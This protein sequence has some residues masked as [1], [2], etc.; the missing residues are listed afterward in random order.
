MLNIFEKIYNE[1]YCYYGPQKWW[2]AKTKLEI[3]VGAVLTQN[4]SWRNA[5]NAISNL[6]KNKLLSLRRLLSIDDTDLALLI[7]SSGY[8]NLKAKRLKNL[9]IFL[10]NEY[11]LS[12]SRMFKSETDFLREQLLSLYGFGEE[13]VDCILLYAGQRPVFVV[14]AYTRRIFSRHGLIGAK[15][16]YALIQAKITANIKN[17]PALFNEYHALIVALGKSIC[18]KKPLCHICP[19]SKIF[20]QAAYEKY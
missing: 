20:K 15:D 8:Y 12:L 13:T 9:I 11:E 19:V 2:P 6:K 18:R 16:S 10:K 3:I 7:R 14:D 5:E 1:L 4:T 17:K